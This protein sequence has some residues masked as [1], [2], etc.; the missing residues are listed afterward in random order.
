MD[1]FDRRFQAFEEVK[2][3]FGSMFTMGTKSE[4]ITQFW[5]ATMNVE[6]LFGEEIKQYREEIFRRGSNI[7]DVSKDLSDALERGAPQ[8]E[9][10]KL[11]DERRA[12]V[13]WAREQVG[14]VGEKFKRY[15]DLSRL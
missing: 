7:A 8:E 1:L 15:L 4:E 6:F 12:E 11:S 14:V 5:F 9:R 13:K 3:V 10:K 2:K